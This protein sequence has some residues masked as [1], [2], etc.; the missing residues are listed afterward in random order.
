M[1]IGKIIWVDEVSGDDENDGSSPEQAIL[2]GDRLS[3]L[4]YRG[5]EMNKHEALIER[6]L[7]AIKEVFG[8]TSVTQEDA[9]LSLQSL[10]DE[11]RIL[12]ETLE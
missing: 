12:I 10:I 1:S 4:L 5:K 9:K 3:E 8:D 7:N 6:A 2:S 11:I